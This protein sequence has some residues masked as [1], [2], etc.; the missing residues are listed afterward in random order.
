V[1]RRSQPPRASSQVLV[2]YCLGRLVFDFN[3]ETRCFFL[4]A[5]RSFGSGRPAGF[6]GVAPLVVYL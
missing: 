6:V 2:Y 3:H 1:I 4:S 5:S